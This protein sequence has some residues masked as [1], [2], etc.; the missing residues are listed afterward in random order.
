VTTPA[1]TPR[2]A[3]IVW[4][5]GGIL[6]L[7]NKLVFPIIWF[8]LVAA[9][10]LFELVRTGGVFVPK[11]FGFIS[12]FGGFMTWLSA[13]SMARLERIGYC[14]RE[15]VISN[16]W[17]EVRIPFEQVQAVEPVWWYQRRM[18]RI[19]LRSRTPFGDTVYYIPKWAALRCFYSRP[20]EELREL[21]S[22]ENLF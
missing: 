10:L 11:G 4:I 14:G 21:V 22:S 13:W 16:Y 8:S 5:S 6:T 20:D 12:A 7:L 17:R 15:L 18:V 2:G 1:Q 3:S 19:R 9:I